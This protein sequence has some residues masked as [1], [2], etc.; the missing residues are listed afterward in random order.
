[1]DKICKLIDEV[2]KER[3]N[4]AL[5]LAESNLKKAM[6]SEEFQ[7]IEEQKAELVYQI[8]VSNADG[9]AEQEKILRESLLELEKKRNLVLK[10]LGLSSSD[11][12][13]A[14]KCEICKDTGKGNC[15]CKAKVKNE[16]L[17]KKAGIKNLESFDD[18]K[19]RG[20]NFEKTL[21]FLK[22]WAEKFPD[23]S[24]HNV[25][26]SG[27]TGVGKTFLTRC[28]INEMIKKGKYVYFTTAFNL[29]Q[30]FVS[31]CNVKDEEKSL[32]LEPLMESE[33]LVVDDLGTEP[34][35]KNITLNYLY[36]I[37]NER[38]VKNKAT[39]IT[40]NL[41]PDGIIDRYGERIFSRLFDKRNGIALELKGEDFRL[42]K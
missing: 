41:A 23:V 10:K 24:K 5:C 42:K 30:A 38:L 13:P 11:L 6:Q 33:I 18:A 17:L 1:M 25:F 40:S 15:S 26:I 14:F 16:I 2:F 36:L 22:K 20:E 19:K 9:N 3:R 21:W 32:V 28:L 27:E 31:Y 34:I 12:V 7:K 4:E 37:L 8:A 39:F 35:L 29:N